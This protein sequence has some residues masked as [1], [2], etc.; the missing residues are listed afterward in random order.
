MLKTSKIYDWL[1][2]TLI[3]LGAF[4]DMFAPVTLQR[5]FAI[6][7]IPSAAIL[8]VKYHKVI[9]LYIGLFFIIWL[10]ASVVSLI[11][12]PDRSSG[13]KALAYNICSIAVYLE[14]ILFAFKAKNPLKSI[15][16]GWSILFAMTLVVALWEIFTNQHLPFNSQ[17]NVSIMSMTGK[18]VWMIYASVT[19]TNYNTYVL[20]I[21]YCL[22]FI[23][24]SIAYFKHIKWWFWILFVGAVFVLLVNTSRGGIA[25]MGIMFLVMLWFYSKNRMINRFV[26]ILIIA[27][28]LG[29][30]L[31]YSDFVLN[32]MIGRFSDQNIFEDE[33]REDIYIRG[34]KI[35]IESLGIGCGI[36]GLQVSLEQL[37]AN[38]ISAMHNMFLEFLVQYGIVPFSAFAIVL[39]MT[40]RSL[41]KSD[42]PISRFMG[43]AILLVIIP[44]GVI[45]SN[46][47]LDQNL[48]TFLAS[49]FI[50]G[51][52]S[53]EKQLES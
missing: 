12:T 10:I 22:P 51:H 32:Q 50:I 24:A 18:R 3:A 31:Y 41:L 49:L 2:V 37:S 7:F 11:W 45:N 1:I 4:G 25:C 46:Y 9:P 20:V 38:G 52:L 23:L 42:Y 53:V 43:F 28:I 27:A 48:W 5:I 15:L 30:I 19:F 36:G 29:V 34:L 26:L 44:L 39:F 21:L 6:V 14:L 40:I 35:F 17:E 33:I 8:Y 16:T 13:I 47:L